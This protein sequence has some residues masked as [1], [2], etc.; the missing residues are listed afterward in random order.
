MACVQPEP[1]CPYKDNVYPSNTRFTDGC[2]ECTCNDDATVTCSESE[3]ATCV[4]DGTGYA[5]GETWAAGDGCNI[6]TC[7]SDGSIDCTDAPC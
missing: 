3:C 6:C 1:N 7:V 4:D 2:Y 5:A